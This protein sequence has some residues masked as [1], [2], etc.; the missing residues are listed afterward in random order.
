MAAGG[1]HRGDTDGLEPDDLEPSGGARRNLVTIVPSVVEHTANS[2]ARSGDSS[3]LD[4]NAID[5]ALVLRLQGQ[6]GTAG[7]GAG[8]G[9]EGG[10]GGGGGGDKRAWSELILRHQRR[11]FATCMRY[12]NNPETAADLTQDTFVKVIQSIGS[13]D[14]RAQFATWLTR[15]T[16]NVCLSHRRSAL[17]RKTEPLPGSSGKSS[18]SSSLRDAGGES[19]RSENLSRPDGG[20][21]G[22]GG[23]GGGGELTPVEGVELNERRRHLFAALAEVEPD[24]R[25]LL[26][27]RDVQ[28]L[29]YEQI[30]EVLGVPMGTLKSRL[31]RAR[32][33]LREQIER[34]TGPKGKDGVDETS[35]T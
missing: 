10:T 26:I 16:I 12:C 14:H 3:G 31:F 30:A 7:R 21:L 25:A 19:L 13:F 8:G 34:M 17:V 18:L 23:V 5:R 11:V 2:A 24:Q 29:E 15:I 1:D 33:A 28:G 4:E 22:G 32:L 35:E 9:G 20:A 6:R 27:L